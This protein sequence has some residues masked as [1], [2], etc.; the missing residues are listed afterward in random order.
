MDAK[1]LSELYSRMVVNNVFFV[2]DVCCHI[3]VFD[4]CFSE[5]CCSLFSWPSTTFCTL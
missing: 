1:H 2:L 4:R 5:L 3:Q